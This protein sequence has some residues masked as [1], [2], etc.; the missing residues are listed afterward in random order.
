[1]QI[2]KAAGLLTGRLDET[3]FDSDLSSS[4]CRVSLVVNNISDIKH[5]FLLLKMPKEVIVID[6][7][8]PST[9]IPWGFVICGGRDQ[10]SHFQSAKLKIHNIRVLLLK[11]AM[12]KE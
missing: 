3:H 9:N 8:R 11:L 6:V 7:Q 5:R 2:I 4:F 12:L 10:V 1:M